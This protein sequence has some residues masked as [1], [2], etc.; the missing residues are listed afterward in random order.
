MN[1]KFTVILARPDWC[2]DPFGQD[3]L[4]MYVEVLENDAESAALRAQVEAWGIDNTCQTEINPEPTGTHT[5]YYVVA[6]FTGWQASHFGG[7]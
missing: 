2:A 1:H 3:H 4:V 5:D 7:D 6:V